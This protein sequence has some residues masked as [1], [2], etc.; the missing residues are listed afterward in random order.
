MHNAF[1][2]KAQELKDANEAYATAHI[3]RRKIPSS[4][5]PGDK[6]IITKDGSIHGWIGGG[7]TRG[8]VLK[9]ALEAIQENKPRLVSISPSLEKGGFEGTKTYRMTCQ[10]GGEVDVYIEPILPSPQLMVFGSSH[11]AMAL[12]KIAKA[13][14]YQ[15]DVVTTEVDKSLF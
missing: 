15:V 4:G 5:K 14:D 6:A 10:S 9:E 13:M 3:V 7:C 8:I 12:A 11:I 1:L 2:Y